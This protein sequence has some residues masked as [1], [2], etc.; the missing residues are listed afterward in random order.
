MVPGYG[1]AHGNGSHSGICYSADHYVKNSGAGMITDT[2]S[3]SSAAQATSS[4]SHDAS[5]SGSRR[6]HRAILKCSQCRLDKQRVSQLPV[7]L[8][9]FN[10]SITCFPI[11]FFLYP[12]SPAE[13]DLRTVILGK[14]CYI[15]R[16]YT[17]QL[18]SLHILE[19]I[20]VHQ[21]RTARW[22][23]GEWLLTA[24]KSGRRQV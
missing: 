12:P 6:R 4:N 5:N 2:G 20:P 17:P 22:G 21:S 24:E 9:F 15:T 18:P 8:L 13:C 7:T 11:V 19:M 16:K 1:D 3:A 23:I 10:Y 14:K